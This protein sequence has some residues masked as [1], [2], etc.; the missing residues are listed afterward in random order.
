MRAYIYVYIYIQKNT[1]IY[2]SVTDKGWNE[3]QFIVF[4]GE[5]LQVCEGLQLARH[6]FQSMIILQKS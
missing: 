2:R 1:H 5:Q 3:K 6:I 4:D